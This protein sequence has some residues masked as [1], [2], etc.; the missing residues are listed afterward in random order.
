V[1]FKTIPD[2]FAIRLEKLARIEK[3]KY[4]F[5]VPDISLCGFMTLYRKYLTLYVSEA[6]ASCHVDEFEI[7]HSNSIKKAL[8]NM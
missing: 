8:Y 6:M 2:A 7:S 1:T 4:D 3:K 5:N